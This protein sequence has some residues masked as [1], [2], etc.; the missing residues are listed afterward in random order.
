M[1]KWEEVRKKRVFTQVVFRQTSI[2]PSSAVVPNP[3]RH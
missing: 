2:W 1:D 3:P